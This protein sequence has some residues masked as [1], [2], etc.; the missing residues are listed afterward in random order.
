[1][2]RTVTISVDQLFRRQPGGIGTYVRGLIEG[3][4]SI[5]AQFE[6]LGVGP[7]GPAPS[8]LGSLPLRFTSAGVPLSVLTRVWPVMPLGV[9]RESAIVH[10]TS[11]NGPFAGG[12]SDAVHSVA[13]HDLMWRD[14]PQ[15]TTRRG[16]KFHEARLALILRREDLRIFTTSPPLAD[17]LVGLGVSSSRIHFVRLGVDEHRENA[18]GNEEIA[19]LL[20]SRGVTGP[21]TL[22]AGTREPRKNIERLVAAHRAARHRR[23]ELG[24]LVIVGPEGWGGVATA[25]AVVLGAVDRSVLQGLYRD[26]AVLVYVPLSEGWGL[27]PVEALYVG[28]RVVASATVPSVATNAQVVRVDP[29]DVSSIASGL[30]EA[31]DQDDGDLG[32]R[33]RASSVAE[34]TWRHAALDHVAGWQ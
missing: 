10:A 30:C 31:L 3:L 19:A 9:S 24:P 13:M 18:A 1:V 22:F 6:L 26:A 27:P 16:A 33:A 12:A 34:L 21:Y 14:Q 17:R 5:D 28:T 7:R 32:R 11:M 23:D 25:D 29:L 2:K 15:S 20:L 8:E 4:A